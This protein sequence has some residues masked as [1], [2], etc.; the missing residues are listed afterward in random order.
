MHTQLSL[1]PDIRKNVLCSSIQEDVGM[2]FNMMLW[3]IHQIGPGVYLGSIALMQ[4][5]ISKYIH[6][7]T[8]I[9][10]YNYGPT[11]IIWIVFIL[12]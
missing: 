11:S 9:T 3:K 4:N 1:I 7:F 5:Q 2:C 8:W 12:G 10:F 6:K